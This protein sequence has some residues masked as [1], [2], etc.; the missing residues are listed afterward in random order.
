MFLLI[1]NYCIKITAK[2]R[3]NFEVQ[4]NPNYSFILNKFLNI[5]LVLLT[6][7]KVKISK[8]ASK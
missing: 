1:I 8:K 6:R 4:E 5:R 2:V 7:F 3:F